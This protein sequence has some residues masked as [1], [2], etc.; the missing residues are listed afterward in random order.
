MTAFQLQGKVAGTLDKANQVCTR[1]FL[2]VCLLFYRKEVGV[3]TTVPGM[4]EALYIHVPDPI[5]ESGSLRWAFSS[6]HCRPGRESSRRPDLPSGCVA[7]A[8]GGVRI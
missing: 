5:L 7:I 8:H 6:S 1:L 3:L 4:R 2:T